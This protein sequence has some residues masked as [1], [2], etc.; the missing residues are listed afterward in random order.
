MLNVAMRKKLLQPIL[1]GAFEFPGGGTAGP[2]RP[3]RTWSRA[4]RI[5]S[6]APPHL[7]NIVQII[8]ETGLRVYKELTPM[9]GRTK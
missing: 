6:Q 3:I 7:P 2:F 4:T 5:E 1:V 9:K 8:T